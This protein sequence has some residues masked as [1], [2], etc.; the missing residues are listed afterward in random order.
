MLV[1]VLLVLPILLVLLVLQMYVISF[2]MNSASSAAGAL[3]AASSA[4]RRA[5][6]GVI[7]A[8]AL[9]F[10]LAYVA[11]SVFLLFHVWRSIAHLGV[12]FVRRS[13][14]AEGREGRIDR[15][16]RKAEVGGPGGLMG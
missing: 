1:L 12:T 13:P 5:L 8:L 6:P 14:P 9:A 2:F 16:L 7:G 4:D 3:I 11:F 10:L 15:W